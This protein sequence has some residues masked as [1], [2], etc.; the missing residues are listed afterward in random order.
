MVECEYLVFVYVRNCVGV[1]ECD[2]VGGEGYGDCG[3]GMEWSGSV[4]VVGG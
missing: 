4:G 3:V 2:I 1:S